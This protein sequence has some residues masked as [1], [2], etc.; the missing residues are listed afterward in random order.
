VTAAPAG[1]PFPRLTRAL[2][3]FAHE[4]NQVGRQTAF[5]F[6]A[7]GLIRYALVHYKLEVLRVVASMSM[8]V[9]ALIVIGGSVVI[10]MTLVGSVATSSSLLGHEQLA[11]IGVD[12]LGGFFSAYFLTRIA[13]PL[14][15][16][17]GLAA[18]IGAAATAQIGAMRIAEEID[19]LEAMGIRTIAYL[20]STRIMSAVFVAIPL[21]CMGAEAGYLAFRV[22]YALGF[23]Q[24]VGVYNHYFTTYLKPTDLV[25]SLIEVLV[26]AFLIMLVH[27]YYGF[28]ASG[29]PAGVGEA[30]G[31]A[32]R[33]SLAL[34]VTSTL[35]IGM[36]VYGTTGDFN[37]S[38]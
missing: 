10:I 29:G 31:R 28:N 14:I 7:I 24:G 37:L 11:H 36:A 19:A 6:K 16:D 27:T 4:W 23:G 9:G 3:G 18:T 15:T 1:F 12:A 38:G 5:Y 35:V 30:V 26:T 21:F 2:K 20:V 34:S 17:V 25:W 13:F 33:A 22:V 32:V 8:G